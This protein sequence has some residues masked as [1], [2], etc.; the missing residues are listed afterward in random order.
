MKKTFIFFISIV[1]CLNLSAKRYLVQS[2]EDGASTWRAASTD[3]EIVDLKAIDKTIGAWYNALTNPAS[4]EE[5]IEI[6][7]IKGTFR[8]TALATK[9]HTHLFGGF[10]GTESSIEER[11]K[12]DF[13]W[14]FS[15]ASVLDANFSA[16]VLLGGGSR[17]NVFLD[18]FTV[19]NSVNESAIKLRGSEIVQN[20]II[21]ENS[22][23]LGS[24]GGAILMYQGGNVKNCL[25]RNNEAGSG[26]GI[27]TVSLG[28]RECIIENCVF[29]NNTTSDGLGSAI[30]TETALY[31]LIRNC[32][33]YNNNGAVAIYYKS[34]V[35][36]GGTMANMTIA[37]TKT[38]GYYSQQ[39]TE[40]PKVYNSAFWGYSTENEEI[41]SQITCVA[42]GGLEL[43]N[44]AII[45]P[46]LD[47]WTVSNVI[48]LEKDNT[49]SEAGLFYAGFTDP[50]ND[51][52]TLTEAS[53]L[54]D[55]GIKIEG[56]TPTTDVFGVERSITDPMDIGCFEFDKNF[57][58]I[59][60]E[61]N[62]SELGKVYC[63]NN[64]LKISNVQ[65]QTRVSI[66]DVSGK[67]IKEAIISNNFEYK[68]NSGLYIIKLEQGKNVTSKKILS[69]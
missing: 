20:C 53:A 62:Y 45:N 12:G 66:F 65:D 17:S 49:G 68:I 32:L 16:G 13:P 11:K 69:L 51:D 23:K 50:D 28:T 22:N 38:K 21:E 33:T 40:V 30:Y 35:G 3:E 36:G 41:Y 26:G 31:C 6:W 55:N 46:T 54:I 34:G 58:S 63:E 10:S 48:N 27:A 61:K 1:C 7:V 24:K 44:C 15:N 60:D 39:Q 59:T 67:K 9:S 43:S 64:I 18:G 19:C 42:G 25:I 4:A 56:I 8:T 57:L 47:T 52:Y 37:E 14:A 2:G 29:E 5:K